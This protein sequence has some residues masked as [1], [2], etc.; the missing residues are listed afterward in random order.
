MFKLGR[1]MNDRNGLMVSLPVAGDVHSRF[2][3]DNVEEIPSAIVASVETGDLRMGLF[4]FD[5]DDQFAKYI[6]LDLVK[7]T[8]SKK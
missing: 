1:M 2:Y 6:D 4:Q 8:I 3:V 7:I 5:F